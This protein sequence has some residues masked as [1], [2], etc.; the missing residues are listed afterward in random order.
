MRY[1]FPY[2]DAIYLKRYIICHI[3]EDISHFSTHSL[4]FKGRINPFNYQLE[5]FYSQGRKKGER[6]LGIESFKLVVEGVDSPL[7]AQGVSGE[8]RV[9]RIHIWEDISHFSTHS[10]RFKGRINPFNYQ[11]EGC[12]TH[13]RLNCLYPSSYDTGMC[14]QV[15]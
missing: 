15:W 5:G 6:V 9:N 11:L 7:E 2:M 12:P 4:R 1:I 3:W 10:L 14:A 13:M 8:M